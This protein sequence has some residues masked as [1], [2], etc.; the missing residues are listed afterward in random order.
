MAKMSFDLFGALSPTD[1]ERESKVSDQIFPFANIV[2]LLLQANGEEPKK[3]D[4]DNEEVSGVPEQVA[5]SFDDNCW[6]FADNS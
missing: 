6:S 1:G 2:D 4:G 5:W 3:T